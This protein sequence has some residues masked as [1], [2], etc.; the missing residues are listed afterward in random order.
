MMLFKRISTKRS[1]LPCLH[2]LYAILIMDNLCLYV[3]FLKQYQN[4]CKFEMLKFTAIILN[5]DV[6]IISSLK[7][8]RISFTK[9]I[10]KIYTQNILYITAGQMF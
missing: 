4:D 8:F 6:N 3:C 5:S 1:A 2:L 7:Q 10:V 9:E